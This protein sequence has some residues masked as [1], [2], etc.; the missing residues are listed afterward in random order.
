MIRLIAKIIASL[1]GIGFVPV[2]PGTVASAVAAIIWW[3][4]P[5]LGLWPAA[6]VLMVSLLVGLVVSHYATSGHGDPAWVVIDE[7]VGMWLVLSFL[8]HDYKLFISAFI[9]FRFFDIKK[10]FGIKQ[11]QYLPGAWGVMLDD[12]AA[13]ALAAFL[14]AIICNVRPF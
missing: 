5:I 10:P 9:L 1:F 7:L 11:V 4:M 8:P 14:L 6:V 3:F 13:G 12:C 2:M